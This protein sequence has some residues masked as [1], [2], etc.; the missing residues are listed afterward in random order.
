MYGDDGR[1]GQV[2]G[3]LDLG[4][5]WMKREA[6]FDWSVGLFGNVIEADSLIRFYYDGNDATVSKS[7]GNRSHFIAMI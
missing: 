3:L 5:E 1:A 7:G 4:G 6:L 2:L